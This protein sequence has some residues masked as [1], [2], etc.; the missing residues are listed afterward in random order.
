LKRPNKAGAGIHSQ[1]ELHFSSETV[2]IYGSDLQ[3]LW[4]QL[5]VKPAAHIKH[6]EHLIGAERCEVVEISMRK[7]TPRQ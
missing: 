3:H 1:I 7:K 2:D 5:E 6:G 4:E